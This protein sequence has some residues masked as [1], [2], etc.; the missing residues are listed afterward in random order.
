MTARESEFDC[1]SIRWIAF[2]LV[3]TL[4]YPDPPVAR[5]YA[6][7]AR[8]Y[9]SQLSEEIVRQRFATAFRRDDA[10]EVAG[11][12]ERGAADGLT[13]DEQRERRRWER[14]VSRVLDDV[15]EPEKC[16][17]ELFAWFGRA[18]AW[19]LYADVPEAL[20]RC[21]AAGYRLA[22]ASNF[23]ARLHSV[24]AGHPELAAIAV[25]V[26]SSE[27]GYR[28]P[29]GRFYRAL[30]EAAGCRP[31]EMLMVG[32]DETNDVHGARLA[33]LCAV[34]IDRGGAGEASNQI[35]SLVELADRLVE[36]RA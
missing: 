11:A 4:V 8:R 31:H 18:S 19:A 29:S 10:A 21:A 17:S 5:V 35:R 3:G 20:R 12:G 13:T 16:F 30:L 15:R 25:Q 23:D 22:L 36:S 26:V 1:R 27:A 9:G 33:G 7:V 28:K 2:D 6:S 32:D 14:I 24:V 34:R